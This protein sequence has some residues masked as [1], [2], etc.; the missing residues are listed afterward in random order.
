MAMTESNPAGPLSSWQVFLIFL[1]LGLTSFGGPAA[2]L[3]FFHDEFVKRR[4][5]LSA[6]A[7]GEVVALC[8][9]LPGPASSQVGLT[10]GF[11]RGHY[12][13]AFAAW[14][15]FTLPSA[16]AMALFAFGLTFWP[17]AGSGG[18]INGLKLFVVAVVAQAVWQMGQTLCPDKPRVAIALLVAIVLLLVG[19][20]WMQILALAM[21]AIAGTALELASNKASEP[22]H[23]PVQSR[24]P[25]WFALAFA[26]LLGLSL[27][28]QQPGSLAWVWAELYRAGALVFGGGHVVLPWLQEG[29]VE[30][31]TMPAD[32]F[33]AGYGVAQAVP[34]PLFTFSAF[35][36]GAEA[37]L[38]GAVIAVVAVFLPG[39][40]LVFAGLPLW[41]WLREHPQAR[42]A[43]AGVNAGVVG[44]LLAALYD[45]VWTSAV[46]GATDLAFALVFW[47]ALAV[48]RWP[49]WGLAVAS[50]ILG[51]VFL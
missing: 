40:L 41:S 1:R 18:W 44:L 34:G 14:L 23:V 5:W 27:L 48:L 4:Q 17:E 51:A 49:V 29:F 28:P 39:T 26:G 3:G 24:K 36:G 50:A 15:G 31:G 25:V 22:L 30:S 19:A 37:G 43:L 45:P 21:A 16:I 35:L 33:L 7:Y 13:G 12:G 42:S 11:L 10:I 20:T 2:H 9:L 46:H 47:L 38:A 32:T 8:Q 6:S